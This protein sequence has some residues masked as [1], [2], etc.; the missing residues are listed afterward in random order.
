ML[1]WERQISAI[2]K[3][4]KLSMLKELQNW[5]IDLKEIKA[6]LSTRPILFII[7]V[8]FLVQTF[9]ASS[10]NVGIPILASTLNPKETTLLQGLIWGSWA[11]GNVLTTFVLPKLPFLKNRMEHLYFYLSF[12]LSLSFILLLSTTSYPVIFPV[13]FVTGVLDGVVGIL[14]SSIFQ[15]SENR[16]RGR[17]FGVSTLVNRLGFT[18]GFIFTPLLI[19][20]FPLNLMVLIMHGTVLFTVFLSLGTIYLSTSLKKQLASC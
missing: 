16:I 11:C 10:Q 2:K 4:R 20:V 18:V 1:K 15:K 14:N 6:Y 17:V 13:G 7:F 19:K 9:A 3:E 12:F 5:V 8:L